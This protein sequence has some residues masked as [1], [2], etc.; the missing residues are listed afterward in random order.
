MRFMLAQ[1]LNHTYM[2]L[3]YTSDVAVINGKTSDIF[4][5]YTV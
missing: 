4:S 1:R 3:H 5:D 2:I